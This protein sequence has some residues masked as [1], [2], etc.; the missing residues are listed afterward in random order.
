ML[1]SGPNRN[2]DALVHHIDE[3]LHLGRAA[4]ARGKIP[5]A[6][7][8]RLLSQTPRKY[9]SLSLISKRFL[10]LPPADLGV[11]N[12]IRP[13]S[14]AYHTRLEDICLVGQENVNVF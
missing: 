10:S 11:L 2:L 4:G 12:K 13:S 1:V 6:P 8:Q 14:G 9:P 5:A 3:H 7:S